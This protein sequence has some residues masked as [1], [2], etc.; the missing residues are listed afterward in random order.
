[1][2]SS[3]RCWHWTIGRPVGLKAGK[4]VD[5]PS[6]NELALGLLA[7][8]ADEIEYCEPGDVRTLPGAP[9]VRA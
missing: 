4:K 9:H 5:R 7:A 1:M 2:P 6:S 3:R 8:L